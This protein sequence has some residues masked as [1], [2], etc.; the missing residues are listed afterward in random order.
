MPWTARRGYGE[1]VDVGR[2]SS[3][4]SVSARPLK[5]MA[6]RQNV[7]KGAAFPLPPEWVGK[8]S[9]GTSLPL[10]AVDFVSPSA[11]LPAWACTSFPTL[12][13]CYTCVFVTSVFDF[14]HRVLWSAAG[15]SL[16]VCCQARLD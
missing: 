6:Y 15:Y 5:K 1:D 8:A 2:D 4:A 9:P 10:V 3:G 11:M 16:G 12:S 13:C 7:F 14:G